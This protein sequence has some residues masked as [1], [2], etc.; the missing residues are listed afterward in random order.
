[1]V[2]SRE[3]VLDRVFKALG[4]PTRRRMLGRLSTRVRAVSDLAEPFDM[5]L[6]AAS[7]H[8]AVLERAG[9]IQRTRRG[10]V[11]FCSITPK[12]LVEALEWLNDYRRLWEEQFDKL[13]A[14][15]ARKSRKG[16]ES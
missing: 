4:D 13:D 3:K 9:L 6:A 15:L 8:L 10:R 1:M 11:R 2:E 7:K 12:P 16:G 14:Y 5:T